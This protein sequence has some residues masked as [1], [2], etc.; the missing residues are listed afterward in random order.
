MA[1]HSKTLED[2]VSRTLPPG[3]CWC[4]N[5]AWF[6]LSLVGVDVANIVPRVPVQTLM[7]PLLVEVMSN[8]SRSA[9][10]HENR[11]ECAVEDV[12]VGF[13]TGERPTRAHEVDKAHGNAPVHVENEVG[14]LRRG[15]AFHLQCVVEQRAARK[16][17]AHVFLDDRN[18][19]VGVGRRFDL[20]AN[21]HD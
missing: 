6:H 11:V 3:T 12:F 20:V 10:E 13:F 2:S 8:Q 17:F 18:T 19:H 4:T 21:S 5:S 7:Q 1:V 9:S 16:V 14:F 15:D